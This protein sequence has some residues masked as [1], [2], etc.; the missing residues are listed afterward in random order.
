MCNKSFYCGNYQLGHIGLETA[1]RLLAKPHATTL[2]VPDARVRVITPQNNKFSCCFLPLCAGCQ[3]VKQKRIFPPSRATIVCTFDAMRE[4]ILI[5]G[6][7]VS[8]DLYV[9]P[10]KGRLGISFGKEAET[11]QYSSG[12]IFVDHAS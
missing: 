12:S 9:S 7:R 8:V 2:L 6:R 1:K 5:P 11:K 3:F 4:D 10:E